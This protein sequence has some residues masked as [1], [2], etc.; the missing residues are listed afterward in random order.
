VEIGSPEELS[1]ILDQA[2]ETLLILALAANRQVH[3]A[4][5]AMGSLEA[6]AKSL[7]HEAQRD[8]L[9]GL[10]N[11]AYFDHASRRRS[12]RRQSIARR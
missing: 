8:G 9:T 2:K 10:Y 3:D 11:R 7:E 4:K 6:K 12:P 1:A 5:E